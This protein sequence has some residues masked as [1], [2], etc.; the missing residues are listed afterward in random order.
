MSRG[1]GLRRCEVGDLAQARVEV[2]WRRR[3]LRNNGEANARWEAAEHRRE[4]DA[5]ALVPGRKQNSEGFACEELCGAECADCPAKIT[6]R[7]RRSDN[8]LEAGIVPQQ[9]KSESTGC[10]C[11]AAVWNRCVQC[12]DERRC[13]NGCAQSLRELQQQKIAELCERWLLRP[14]DPFERCECRESCELG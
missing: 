10:G 13:V 1:Q 9:L 12:S 4:R 8:A 11:D 7:A 2:Q 5:R 14:D 3:E 6:Q